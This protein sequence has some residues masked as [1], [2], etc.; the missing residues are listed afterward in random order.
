MMHNVVC[1]TASVYG[2]WIMAL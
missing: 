1:G 2:R